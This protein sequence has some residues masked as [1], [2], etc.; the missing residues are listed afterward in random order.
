[1]ANTSFIS[2]KNIKKSYSSRTILENVNLEIDKDDFI[3]IK[4]KSGA[5]KSTLLNIIALFEFADEGKYEFNG[6][7][8][9][10]K[11][12]MHSH[13]RNEQIGFVFQAYNLLSNITVKDNI[14]LPVVYS[15]RNIIKSHIEQRIIELVE[16]LDI[17]HLL[18]QNV[19]NLSGGEKQRV[20]IARGL[21]M[22]PQ[23]LIADEPTGNLDKESA[24]IVIN[25]MKK[26]NCLGTAVLI[27]THND[28]IAGYGKKKYYL[29]RGLLQNV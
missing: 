6:I 18:N 28:Y 17:S 10:K 15:R 4:G 3:T 14:M 5:G 9:L 24:Q 12:R 22:N 19:N 16:I 8:L 20:A 1:M 21:V 29:E 25:L 23:L 2:I 26:I 7:D 11:K 13:I 27:V